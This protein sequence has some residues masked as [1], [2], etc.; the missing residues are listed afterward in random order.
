MD[1]RTGRV[2]VDGR[3]AV[4]LR[5]RPALARLLRC[6]LARPDEALDK[7]LL[8][9]EAW[10]LPYRP[11]RDATV[12]KAVARLGQALDP[13]APHRFLRWDED[14]RLVLTSP[15]TRLVPA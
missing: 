6:V 8:F 1:E 9:A 2:V 5:A 15:R 4:E 14:G 10:R 12:Y 7:A 3:R 11:A 13:A